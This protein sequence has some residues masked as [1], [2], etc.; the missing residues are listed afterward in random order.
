VK[1]LSKSDIVKLNGVIEEQFS[2]SDFF[3]KKDRVV[4]DDI[5]NKVVIMKEKTALFFYEGEKLVPTLRLLLERTLLKQVTV[6][7]GAVKFMSSGADVMRP[8]ITDVDL[9]LEKG[10]LAVIVDETHKKPLCVARALFSGEEMAGM[11]EGKVLKNVHF[12][13]DKLWNA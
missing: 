12:V 9:S 10:E 8:G 11:T 4:L 7:M 6:D 13:G 1:Q 5:E 2:V 3:G